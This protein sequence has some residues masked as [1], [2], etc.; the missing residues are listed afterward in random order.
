MN[1]GSGRQWGVTPPLS[2]A[3]ATPKEI[4]QNNEL[5]AELKRQG[6]FE[7]EADTQKRKQVLA[8]L[9]KL[10]VEFVKQI[11]LAKHMTQS[12]ASEA[13][14][15]IFT[16]GSFRLGVYGPGSDIDTLMVVPKHVTRED[17]FGTFEQTLR[18]LPEVTE[19]AS[20]PDAYVPIIKLKFS[21]ISIDL[22]FAR[23][24]LPQIK[25]DLTLEDS[26]IL[27][28][29]D[30]ATVRSLNGQRV[31]D[32]I[33]RLVPNTG[34]FKHALRT[35]KLWAQRR[36]IYSNIM[37]FPG[38]VAWA[39]L[40]ARVCQLYPNAVSATIVSKFFKILSV[41][42]WPQPVQLKQSEDLGYPNFRVWN[43]KANMAD[44]SHIMPIITPAYPSM[45]ATHN[46]NRCTLTI[47][48]QE[49]IRAG[50]ITD[51]ILMRKSS[52]ADLFKKHD[53]FLR[54]KYYLVIRCAS[55]SAESQLQWGGLVQSKLRVFVQKLDSLDS[56]KLA[57]P[58]VEGYDRVHYCKDMAEAALVS[59]IKDVD[60]K[61]ESANLESTAK[62]EGNSEANQ[63]P[64]KLDLSKASENDNE[65]GGNSQ[66]IT[67]FSTSYYIGLQLAA[68]DTKESKQINLSWQSQHFYDLVKAWPKYDEENMSICI[69]YVRKYVLLLRLVLLLTFSY[70]L[71]DDVF[72]PGEHKPIRRQKKKHANKEPQATSLQ[73]QEANTTGGDKKRSVENGGNTDDTNIN[74]ED[75]SVSKRQ[76]QEISVS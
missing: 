11:S 63:T 70:D 19:L 24:P 1:A 65:S 71:P 45:C 13:G 36:A 41:W 50:E 62:S 4:D 72:E 37:G 38:G 39:M 21:G 57:H 59:H 67:L 48:I 22:I 3:T 40:V 5:I 25:I 51:N 14:G 2:L 20:V 17:F 43:P 75:S 56:L 32:E 8:R 73:S 10:T 18:T 52:W 31:T 29:L 58:F 16:Y 12:M 9:Q 33:L 47:I 23:L 55:L 28:N 46:V 69:R 44:R 66:P 53:F 64:S 54:Y 26:T 76:K 6:S 7:P 34:V 60:V 35:I 68:M 30:D 42:N 74:K 15:K 49:M 27:K 61:A